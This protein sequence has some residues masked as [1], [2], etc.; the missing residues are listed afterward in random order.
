MTIVKLK[1]QFIVFF[2]FA[3]LDATFLFPDFDTFVNICCLLRMNLFLGKTHFYVYGIKTM[4]I[5]SLI[6]YHKKFHV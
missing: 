4:L 6:I 2:L 5:F 1:L 3:R